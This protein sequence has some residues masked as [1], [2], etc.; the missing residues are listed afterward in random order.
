MELK[1]II[2]ESKISITEV[3]FKTG[4]TTSTI[5]NWHHKK[6]YPDIKQMYLLSKVLKMSFCSL[7]NAV[8]KNAFSNK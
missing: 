8:Y 1:E 3:A 2:K 6:T 4:V 7:F 5:E